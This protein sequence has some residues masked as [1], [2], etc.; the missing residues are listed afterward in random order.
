MGGRYAV[1]QWRSRSR[2][3]RS[4]PKSGGDVSR[5]FLCPGGNAQQPHGC[6][7]LH[8]FICR[9]TCARKLDEVIAILQTELSGMRFLKRT[10]RSVVDPASRSGGA[11]G[12]AHYPPE[13]RQLGEQVEGAF[14]DPRFAAELLRRVAPRAVHFRWGE[15]GIFRNNFNAWQDAG[16]HLLP[17]PG[18]SPI[19]HVNRMSDET[20]FG[21]LPCDGIDWNLEQQVGLI[22]TITSRF[23]AE[24][25]AFSDA[26]ND[27]QFRFNNGQ[28]EAVDAEILYGLIRN[29]RPKTI[30]E[31]GF[32]ANSLATA[33]AVTR[34]RQ[35]GDTITYTTINPAAFGDMTRFSG[36]RGLPT[37]DRRPIQD[38]PPEEFDVLQASDMLLIDSSHIF[39]PGSDVEH[40]LL[41]ILPRLAEGVIVHFHD[42]FLPRA[43]PAS[44]V[45][46]EHIFWNEQNVLLAFLSFN[47]AFRV[48]FSAAYLHH[49]HKQLL[50]RISGRYDAAASDPGSLWLQRVSR[51]IGRNDEKQ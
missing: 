27:L 20:V 45:R 36:I 50:S 15:E 6:V 22:G 35:E 21:K 26:K 16:F 38:I 39:S 24:L 30:L 5:S 23:G 11:S 34:N 37:A 44:W 32:G 43:Y 49:G 19:P 1:K 46:A 47:H 25:A 10:E 51:S 42:I 12:R 9:K 31:Y 48:I 2:K 7:I 41:R 13:Y 14:A 40:I 4:D 17:C 29:S 28:F 8:S 33:D 3:S 18:A